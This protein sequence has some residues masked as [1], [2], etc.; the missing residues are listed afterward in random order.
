MSR[1]SQNKGL[2]VRRVET[3]GPG[4]YA[5]G[6]RS[7]L[8]LTVSPTGA[9]RWFVR[10]VVGKRREMSLGSY[11]LVGLAE[12]REKAMEAQRLARQGTDP[13]EHR[14]QRVI[15]ASPTPTFTEV[16]ARY[17]RAHRRAW[18]NLKHQ[19]QWVSTMKTYARPVIGRKPVDSI[20]TEDI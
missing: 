16:A 17:I 12:A 8:W 5:D 11:P 15:E 10:V 7:G 20:V 19:R 4:K 13:V 9:R 3:A 2:T 6:G 14:R 1:Q 18:K